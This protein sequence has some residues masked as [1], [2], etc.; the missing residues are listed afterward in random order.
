MTADE[1]IAATLAT[2]PPLTPEQVAVLRALFRP[3]VQHA[4]AAAASREDA[5]ESISPGGAQ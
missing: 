1:W 3:A 5:A 2:A 4:G